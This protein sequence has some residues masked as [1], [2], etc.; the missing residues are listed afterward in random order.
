MHINKKQSY[1]TCA[2]PGYNH[3]L[4]RAT[5]YDPRFEHDSC[6]VGF[7][8]RIDGNPTHSVVQDAITVLLNLEHRGAINADMR[9]G[10]GAGLLLSMPD[11]FFQRRARDAGF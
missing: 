3:D 11:S 2:F 8:A 6:G 1:S 9:T 4:D 5:L 10:D 7:I